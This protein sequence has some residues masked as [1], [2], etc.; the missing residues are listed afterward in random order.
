M[1]TDAG[2]HSHHISQQ[3]NIELEEIKGSMLEMGGLVEKQLADALSALINA[4]SELGRTVR[5]HDDAVNDMELTID[6]ACSRVIARRQPAASDLRLV[7]GI[8]KAINDLERIGDEAAKI[9]KLAVA[10]ADEGDSSKGYF[11]VRHIGERV[12]HMVNMALD[13]FARYDAEAALTVAKEDVNVDMEYSSAMREMITYMIED[14]RSISRVMNIIWALRSLERAGDHAKNIA[15][16]VVYM[17]MG[18]DVRHAGLSSM[19]KQV[20]S[21]LGSNN[22]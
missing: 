19:E 4:D 6:D 8:I 17:V 15:E 14:P 2:V 1:K 7:M 20:K 10:L 21:E 16:H 13:A 3:F 18:T 22:S 9:A 5:E 12:R 11:E